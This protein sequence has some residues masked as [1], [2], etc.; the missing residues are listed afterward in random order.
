MK[1]KVVFFNRELSWL[2]FNSRVLDQAR[3]EKKP[4][5]ER[6]KFLAIYGTNLDEF[7]MIRVAGLKNLY[8]NGIVKVG[9]DDLSVKK[10]L[11]FID[12]YLRREKKEFEALYFKICAQLKAEGLGIYSY[13]ELDD[14]L[15]EYAK[16]YFYKHLYVIVVPVVMDFKNPLPHLYNLSVS[17]VT[18]LK[19]KENGERMYGIVRI[20]RTI[21]RFVM[22]KKGVYVNIESIVNAFLPSLF[23][24]FEVLDTLLFRITRNADI[25]I[26]EEEAD[27]F[28]ELLS[29]G[30]KARE[31][32][33]IVRLEFEKKI[34]SQ[35]LQDFIQHQVGVQKE[36][37]F[38]YT[39]LLHVGSLWE[40][41]NK[42]EFAHLSNK[43]FTPK[44]LPPL[45]FK[46][47]IFKTISKQDVVLFHPYE[48]FEGVVNFIHQAS[49]DPK[50][51]SIRMTLYRV[52][53]DSPIVEALIRAAENKQ[54]TV[55]VELKAR[56]D[57]ENNLHWAM[58]LEKA[59]AHVIYGVP[60]LKV[61]AKIA[62]VV[63]Q[64][65][66]QLKGYV[67]LSSG[68]YN[69]ISAKIYTDLSYFTANPKIANDAIR[70]FHA[71]STGTS[72]RTM[73]EYL[74]IAPT[75]I[76][77]KILSMIDE[78]MVYGSEGKIIFKANALV[79]SDVIKKLYEASNAGVK[80]WLIIRG[81]CCLVPNIKGMSENIKVISLVG[82]Y[83]EH[84]RIYY[85]AHQEYI[86][87]SSADLMPRNLER[88]VEILIP[89]IQKNL[90][91]KILDILLIQLRDDINAYELQSDGSYLPKELCEM[92]D[93]QSLYEEYVNKLYYLYQQGNISF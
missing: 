91:Q 38:L 50:V 19:D 81:I 62:L 80:I 56:F 30:L 11:D 23:N 48:S 64:E 73:L 84:A 3:D 69:P 83:L 36:D 9:I 63:R 86:Y 35:E 75:Q 18:L 37:I 14:T 2:Q 25:E 65:D 74:N 52:G 31:K 33:R 13:Q 67:H 12:A 32:G 21:E 46:D 44:V 17:I 24:G 4:L 87:F 76:K 20:P 59:G 7:Y 26:E 88:R 93:T 55:L 1:D 40:I 92:I 54:V 39:M 68:N 70:L 53:K 60:R 6:L 57:E 5:L 41:A 58:A 77:N 43:P 8:A 85:C 34:Q 89:V 49:L 16:E 72:Y 10:Q 47:C 28:I 51:I 61:H 29:E 90:Y 27:D 79:D 15:K 42:K 78:E 82:K 66:N 45:N 22:L 71:L